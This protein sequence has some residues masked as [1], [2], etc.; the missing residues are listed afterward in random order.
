MF[1][2]KFAF[3][4]NYW[5]SENATR[6]WRNFDANAIENDFIALKKAGVK[7]LRIFPLWNE[8]QPIK[9][10]TTW[11]G[12]SLE[13]VYED[14]AP[15]D[16]TPEGV[17]GVSPVMMDRLE[18]VMNLCRK[19]GFKVDL[20]IF[21][22]FMSSMNYI[23]RLLESK[24]VF[25]DPIALMW[26]QKY[27]KYI[28]T[29]FANHSALGGWD[30]GNECSVMRTIKEDVP[31]QYSWS[32]MVANAIRVIDKE[33]PVIS[34]LDTLS[35]KTITPENTEGWQL[36]EH[37]E[38]VDILTTHPYPIFRQPL[39][40]I[41]TMRPIIHTA[42]ENSLFEDITGKP[43]FIEETGSIGYQT[44]SLDSEADFI[45]GDMLSAYLHGCHGYFWWCAFDQGD[46]DFAP[47]KYNNIGSDYG[48]M[49]GDRWEKPA[50]DEA[51]RLMTVISQYELPKFERNAVCVVPLNLRNGPSLAANVMCLATQNDIGV[52]YCSASKELPEGKLYI[53]PSIEGNG[54]LHRNDVENLKEKA[55]SGATVYI[56]MGS[57]F[58]RMF[59][60]LSGM[61]IISRESPAKPLTVNIDGIDLPVNPAY[62]YHVS[63]IRGEVLAEFSDKTPAIVC[64]KFGNGKIIISLFSVESQVARL[65]GAFDR[66]DAPHYYKVY[67]LIAKKAGLKPA[68]YTDNIYVC[69]KEH[70]IDEKRSIVS[71]MNYSDSEQKYTVSSTTGYTVKKTL[72][73]LLNGKLGKNDAVIFEVEKY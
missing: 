67:E 35:T 71:L 38:C 42:A 37:A 8:F 54:A 1:G 70:K 61:D 10:L 50:T 49:M 25:T 34:G 48:L 16:D 6:M 28:V 73:G 56:S 22:G 46:I 20:A 7:W 52:R 40:K 51:R 36:L 44:C 60:E 32:L 65:K 30:L 26:E 63:D 27:V 68:F 29:R 21:T 59:P 33:H 15:L 58:L 72:Y 45:R 62:V 57:G 23:P 47:Y 31:A 64:R 18:T 24:N 19:Y 11:V 55:R 14:E 41:N 66:I 43:C 69:A 2:R 12:K 9:E 53:V 17:A 5:A 3:G 13:V 39:D 4:V